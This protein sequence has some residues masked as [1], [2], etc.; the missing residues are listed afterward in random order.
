MLKL[1]VFKSNQ[2]HSLA[3]HRFA[4]CNIVQYPEGF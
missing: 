4:Y 2:P 1:K 3:F